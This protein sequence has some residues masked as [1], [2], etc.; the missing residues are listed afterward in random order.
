MNIKRRLKRIWI[1]RGPNRIWI[2]GSSIWVAGV[3]TVSS[4]IAWDN[5]TLID[6][7]CVAGMM[8]IAFGPPLVAGALGGIAWWIESS[9]RAKPS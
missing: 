2:A 3:V 7:E 8:V 9:F 6:L 5:P 4:Y 1:R